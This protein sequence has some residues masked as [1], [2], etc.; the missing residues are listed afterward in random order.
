MSS[1]GLF[2]V[3]WLGVADFTMCHNIDTIISLFP[4]KYRVK[5]QYKNENITLNYYHAVNPYKVF[6]YSGKT[7]AGK[8]SRRNKK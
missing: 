6:K 4:K 3:W 7:V 8:V 5:M 1:T 2:S